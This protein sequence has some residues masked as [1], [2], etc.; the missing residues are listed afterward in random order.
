MLWLRLKVMLVE[1]ISIGNAVLW[2]SD[3]DIEHENVNFSIM[4]ALVNAKA[5]SSAGSL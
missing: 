3:A 2:L 5:M 1:Y 4:S